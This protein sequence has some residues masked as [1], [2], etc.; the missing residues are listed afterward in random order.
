MSGY[1]EEST[2]LRLWYPASLT[3]VKKHASQWPRWMDNDYLQG[4]S[5][6][7]GIWP[8]FLRTA[9]RW[10]GDDLRI[11]GVWN[12]DVL[13][14][15]QQFPTVVLSHGLSACRFLYSSLCMQ[16]ASHG[17]VVAAVE[18]K[19]ESAASTFFYENESK[20]LSGKKS[21]IIFRTVSATSDTGH[22]LLVRRRQLDI[23]ASECSRALDF[24][25]GVNE[26]RCCENLLDPE[27]KI[28]E[29]LKGRLDLE[30]ASLMGHSFGGATTLVTAAKDDR[31]KQ[32]IVLDSWL[33]GLKNEENM[34]KVL[35]K[36]PK[37]FLNADYFQLDLKGNLDIMRKLVSPT[38]SKFTVKKST[39][40]QFCDSPNIIGLRLNRDKPRID[41]NLGLRINT[42]IVLRYLKER[43][44]DSVK[45]DNGN[46]LQENADH[47]ISDISVQET[48]QLSTK[49]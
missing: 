30:T 33:F 12:A 49:L 7:L 41:G 40:E 39:H 47:I 4:F 2:F 18:H 32:L 17:I 23:R 5:A 1:G 26:G 20:Y 37:L 29:Q 21:T 34:P 13:E 48:T 24:L 35:A 9:L 22:Q 44:G 3:D 25:I 10:V 36:V 16:L 11:P 27:T 46:F 28:L 42:H 19:D 15:T 14:G 6:I 45:W 31:F 8:I 38:D 43:L